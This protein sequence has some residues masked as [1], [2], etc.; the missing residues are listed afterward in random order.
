M[1]KKQG[2]LV[3]HTTDYLY[4]CTC[5]GKPKYVESEWKWKCFKCG[6]KNY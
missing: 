3:Q 4:D 1:K 2:K 6:A 5:G